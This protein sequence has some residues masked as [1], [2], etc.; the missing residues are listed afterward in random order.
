[1]SKRDELLQIRM[2]K[3]ERLLLSKAASVQEV[4]AS[5]FARRAI[6]ERVDRLLTERH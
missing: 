5:D 2:T 6:L 1:M 4:S 3:S